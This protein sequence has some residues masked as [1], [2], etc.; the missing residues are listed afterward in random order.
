PHPNPY[1]CEY[2]DCTNRATLR[3]TLVTDQQLN[4]CRPHAAQYP[5]EATAPATSAT[6][7]RT[8]PTAQ[9]PADDA[10]AEPRRPEATPAPAPSTAAGPASPA[11]TPFRP[12]SQDD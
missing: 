2:G 7:D 11:A 9:G 12:T 6:V 5:T 3:L 8:V 1:G 10:V 4:L